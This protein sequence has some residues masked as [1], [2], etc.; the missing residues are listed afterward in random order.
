MRV[1]RSQEELAEASFYILKYA[2]VREKLPTHQ[3][4]IKR[5]RECRGARTTILL[6][7]GIF[8][9]PPT[10]SLYISMCAIAQLEVGMVC[11]CCRF[12][13]LCLVVFLENV[14][15]LQVDLSLIFLILYCLT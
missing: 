3:N 12:L 9:L 7:I 6:E 4:D 15:V 13:L 2:R 1:T 14:K 8:H 11:W 5:K 10:F